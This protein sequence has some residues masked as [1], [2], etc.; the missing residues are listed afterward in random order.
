MKRNEK[1]VGL[2]MDEQ[3]EDGEMKIRDGKL[4]TIN[5]EMTGINSFSVCFN[6]TT[7]DDVV[8]ILKKYNAIFNKRRREWTA[9]ILR[10]KECAVEVAMF[11]RP[12]GIFVDFIPTSVFELH[13]Y[14]VPFSDSTKEKIVD[15]DYEFDLELKPKIKHLPHGLQQNLYDFQKVGIQYG[16]DK[17]G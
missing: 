11:C 5:F 15:Y 1:K 16:L 8:S 12:R 9:N 6:F 7:P 10:Y 4:R 2:D 3:E 17:F 13:E 14:K